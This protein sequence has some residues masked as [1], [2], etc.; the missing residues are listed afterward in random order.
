MEGSSRASFAIFGCG[1]PLVSIVFPLLL[2]TKRARPSC[3][4][5]FLE[6]YSRHA[7]SSSVCGI[8]AALVAIVV[9]TS[10]SWVAAYN[11]AQ[12]VYK[13]LD[14]F[15][16]TVQTEPQYDLNKST[17]DNAPVASDQPES[18]LT[19][20]EKLPYGFALARFGGGFVGGLGTVL[21]IAL[22]NRRFRQPED[23]LL[24]SVVAMILGGLLELM[25]VGEEGHVMFLSLFVCWQS[26]VTALIARTLSSTQPDTENLDFRSVWQH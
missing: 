6:P 12:V 10:V 19:K 23:L 9:F 17:T 26:A 24:V 22:L 21:G 16:R 14:R 7:I 11:L 4:V 13:F 1:T 8:G 15:E 2:H 3:A 5:S 25:N 18:S 20:T